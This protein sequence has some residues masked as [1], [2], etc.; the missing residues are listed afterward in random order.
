MKKLSGIIF[1][2][3]L[4]GIAEATI[5][6]FL[7]ICVL[8]IGWLIWFPLAY[9]FMWLA[10][11]QTGQP[12]AVV[13]SALIAAAIKLIDLFGPVRI[14]LVINPAVSILL[15]GL[16]VFAIYK[17]G[18]ASKI[19]HPAGLVKI[20]AASLVWR[21]LFCIY[22][23]FLPASFT[24]TPQ[25]SGFEPFI[26]F[27]LFESIINSLLIYGIIKLSPRKRIVP[28]FFYPHPAL[29]LGIL[30][31]ACFIQWRF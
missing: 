2:G 18:V 11:R 1:W 25:I 23:F 7:H 29:S 28:R 9:G 10:Y 4:W 26:R 19:E 12:V 24:S 27:A 31:I 8:P 3:A 21:V 15:E 17:L 20:T 30:I 13:F 16:V 22:L 5:G 6:N 14:D